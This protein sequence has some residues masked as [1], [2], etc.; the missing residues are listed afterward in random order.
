MNEFEKD[1]MLPKKQFDILIVISLIILS[2]ACVS[3]I[4][5]AR[6]KLENDFL[7]EE[8]ENVYQEKQ[9]L[10]ANLVYYKKEYQKLT[11]KSK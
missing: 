1:H 9:L 4:F 5:L 7:K 8:I 10:E 6:Y 3:G 11:I 2:L